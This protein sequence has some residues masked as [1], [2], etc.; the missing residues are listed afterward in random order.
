[1]KKLLQNSPFVRNRVETIDFTIFCKGGSPQYI[2][3]KQ[4]LKD[5][6]LLHQKGLSKNTETQYRSSNRRNFTAYSLYI[7]PLAFFDI[8][9]VLATGTVVL[10]AVLEKKLA[11]SGVIDLAA[12]LSGFLQIAFPVVAFGSLLILIS[13]LGMFL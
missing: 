10:I 3:A 2:A 8:H 12:I 4:K 7:N 11:E 13:K 6:Y 5:L 1:M 9:F